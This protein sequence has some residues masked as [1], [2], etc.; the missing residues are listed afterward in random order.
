MILKVSKELPQLF[1]IMVILGTPVDEL[2]DCSDYECG[3]D[4][5]LASI[6][7]LAH[8]KM[9]PTKKIVLEDKER[10]RQLALNENVGDGEWQRSRQKCLALMGQGS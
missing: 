8:A 7:F 3:R 9:K 4:K 10:Q 6:L 5:I 1:C 2:E